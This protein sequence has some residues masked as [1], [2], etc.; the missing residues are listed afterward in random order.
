MHCVYSSTNIIFFFILH[1]LKITENKKNQ[2]S[3]QDIENEVFNSFQFSS[4]SK[5]K[6][7]LF[8]IA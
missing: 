3:E 1:H 7:E 2:N 4:T 6:N 8:K 5:N